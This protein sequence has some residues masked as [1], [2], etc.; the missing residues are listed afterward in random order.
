[1][2]Q[3]ANDAIEYIHSL[4]RFG[5]KAGLSNISLILERLGNPQHNMKFVHVAGTNGKGS[6]CNML[7]NILISHNYKVGYYTSPYIELFSE[8]I[9]IGNQMISDEDLVY[10]TNM[11]KDISGDLNPIEF[12]F[13]TA[14][15]MQYFS[16]KKCDVIVLEV[17][18]GGRYDATNIIGTPLVNVITS[19]GLDHTAILGD[20]LGQIAFEKAGTIKQGSTVVVGPD[21][22]CECIKVIQKRCASTRSRLII[23]DSVPEH[24]QYLQSGTKFDYKGINYNLSLAGTYQLGNAV[25]AIEA[26]NALKDKLPLD[27]TDIQNGLSSSFWKCRFEIV[28]H[29]PVTVLDGAH[30]SHGIRA[31]MDSIELYFPD[32]KRVFLFS[33]LSEKDWKESAELLAEHCDSVVVTTVPSLRKTNTEEMYK[34]LKSKGIDCYIDEACEH[35]YRLAKSLAGSDGAVFVFG[36]LYLAGALRQSALKN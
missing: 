12:E 23:P 18:L 30:N 32:S 17:G 3:N 8:R 35:A 11:V 29:S 24:V 20:T 14:M 6:V 36:S 5:K 26:A 21:M 19:I 27:D 1:M 7:K 34:L 28:G 31:L 2:I 22:D 13:I 4:H 33:M 9:C 10:Y 16:D 15:A 25:T